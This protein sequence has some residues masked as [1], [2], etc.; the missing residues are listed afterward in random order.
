MAPGLSASQLTL[1]TDP[2]KEQ[3][4]IEALLQVPSEDEGLVRW[5]CTAQQRAILA[6]TRRV[7]K[8]VILKGRQTRCSTILLA[9]Q[10]RKA[11]T[12]Y[13]QNYVVLTQTAEMTQNFRQFILDRLGDLAGMGLDYDIGIN[14]AEKLQLKRM[15][16][17]F[18]WASAEQKVGL[19]GIQTAH[20]VHG[21]EVAHWPEDSAKR[22]IGGLLPASPPAGPFWLES[23]PNGAAGQFYEKAMDGV[24]QPGL[25]WTTQLYPWWLEPKYSIT[26]YAEVLGDAGINIEGLRGNFMASPLEDTLM[27]REG[28]DINQ[29]LWRR[30][31]ERNLL[32]TGAYFAQ[33]YPEDMMTCW[34]ASGVC[35]FH[36]DTFD[37]LAYYRGLVSEPSQRLSSL[38][39]TDPSTS[40]TSVVDF[41][42]PNLSVWEPRQA[43]H[44]YVA[45]LDTSAGVQGGDYSAFPVL[46]TTDGLRHIATF[47]VRATP[48]LVGAMAAAIAAYY[49]WAYVGVERNTYGLEAIHKMQE[50]HYPNLF[51]DFVN[52]PSHPEVGWV[53]SETSRA[54]MLGRFREVVFSH[55]FQSRDQVA[56]TEM[57]GFSWH[58]VPGRTGVIQWKA[59]AERGNDDLVI[60][61]AGAVTIAPYA[62]ARV[63]SGSIDIQTRVITAG[64]GGELTVGPGG[65]VIPDQLPGAHHAWL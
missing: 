7:R 15:K 61:L 4:W 33:E 34:L 62:P 52:Q 31:M 26:S 53:T 8:L 28:L 13:G 60:A 23:T 58:K 56:V 65:I 37:H 32:S 51:Y 45:F 55:R 24:A 59:E 57:G 12:T 48:S 49:N 2:E 18:Y 19:R 39:Y 17:T 47:R 40:I 20:N 25:P 46:D 41:R 38:D 22:I 29:M 35:Y 36:D 54:L 5:R 64:A 21:S 42:G 50:L 6:K 27:A 14:N 30:M 44:R 3:E 9:K 63:K 11:T 16:N 10:L 1:L 43:G